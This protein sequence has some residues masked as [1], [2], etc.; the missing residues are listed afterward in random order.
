[1]IVAIL[2]IKPGTRVTVS[3]TIH[4]VSVPGTLVTV[5][6]AAHMGAVTLDSTGRTL[7]FPAAEIVSRWPWSQHY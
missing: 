3:L 5:A 2:G 4:K 7:W 1:V 6:N